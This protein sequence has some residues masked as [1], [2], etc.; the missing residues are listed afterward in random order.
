MSVSAH[1]IYDIHQEQFSSD[2]LQQGY[3]AQCHQFKRKM[4]FIKRLLVRPLDKG[5]RGI[6]TKGALRLASPRSPLVKGGECD[7]SD[8]RFDETCSLK[9]M[10]L[11]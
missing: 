11:V 4:L 6:L 7:N 8:A 10:T 9:L 3:E 2:A 5:E 1:K